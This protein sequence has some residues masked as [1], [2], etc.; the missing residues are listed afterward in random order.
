MDLPCDGGIFLTEVPSFKMTLAY[1]KLTKIEPE[2][3]AL[4]KSLHWYLQDVPMQRPLIYGKRDLTKH[5]GALL[6]KLISCHQQNSSLV[7]C[8]APE[9]ELGIGSQMWQK[10]HS[11]G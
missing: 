9:G 11:A 1:V 8:L 4:W 6:W 7:L 3:W 5:S 10:Q 2:N